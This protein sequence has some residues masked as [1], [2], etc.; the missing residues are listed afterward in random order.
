MKIKITPILTQTEHKM[1]IDLVSRLRNVCNS[2]SCPNMDC[3]TC[4]LD[5]LTDHAYNLADEISDK[6]REFQIEREGE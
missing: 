6:L 3:S 1:W 5:K 4:P 2:T